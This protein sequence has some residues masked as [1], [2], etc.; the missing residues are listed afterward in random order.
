VSALYESAPIGLG[1]FDRDYRY[2]R[3]NDELAAINGIPAAETLGR[4]LREVVP[5]NAPAVEPVIDRVF[6]TG[7]AVRDLEV[8]GETPLQPGVLRHW[9]TGFY[10]VKGESG[11]V[12]AVGAWVIEI[13]ERKAAEQRESLL[14]GEV[15]HRA[16]NLLAGVQSVVQLTQSNEPG[17]LKQGIIGRIQSLARAHSLLAD[18]RWDGAQLGDLVR[19]EL[20]P[21]LSKSEGRVTAAGPAILLRPAA[22][23]SLAM[24]LHELATN[25]VKYGALSTPGGRLTVEWE[26]SP[27]WVDLSWVER[28]GPAVSSPGA[29]GFGSKIIQAS[30]E[31]QLHGSLEQRWEPEGLACLIRINAREAT[32]GAE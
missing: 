10:P 29:S 12:E 2:L 6:A 23:Q 4:T 21:Y 11:E 1:F 13:S 17:E 20:A 8:T 7:E 22:A 32:S 25:A 28:D 19:E 31:R 15:D 16:K 18:A 14:A 26:R 5:V 30:V 27:E 3:V 9:L 24:V